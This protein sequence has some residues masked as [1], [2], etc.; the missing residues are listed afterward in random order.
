MIADNCDAYRNGLAFVL[1][2]PNIEVVAIVPGGQ[3]AL[4]KLKHITADV[5]LLDIRMP[6]M[7][8]VETCKQV[9]GLHPTIGIIAMSM[10]DACHPDVKEILKAGAD[11]FL[12]K[13][14]DQDKI[15][16]HIHS[17][18][19]GDRCYDKDCL[20]VVDSLINGEQEEVPELD[21]EEMQVLQHI[22]NNLTS[23]Q[24]GRIMHLSP[25]TVDKRR[26]NLLKKFKVESKM[27]LMK[28]AMKLG[29][30]K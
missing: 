23:K 7:D 1:N 25:L 28:K 12:T 10:Y 4:E 29:L 24:I 21:E 27:A 15:L 8:G 9:K 2:S 30:A 14:A 13:D 5:V 22:C 26:E 16:R 6:G 3:E 11:A 20:P 18:A 19:I 17:V